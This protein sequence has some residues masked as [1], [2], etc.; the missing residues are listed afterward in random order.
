MLCKCKDKKD[1]KIKKPPKYG[2]FLVIAP[3]FE[4][5]TYSLEDIFQISR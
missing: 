5:G 4:P 3:G 1:I 2:G